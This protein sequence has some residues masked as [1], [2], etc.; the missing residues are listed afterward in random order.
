MIL[1]IITNFNNN[2]NNNN[3][4]NNNNNSKWWNSVEYLLF[5]I[6]C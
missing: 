3:S 6:Y 1:T 4:N 2:D 5:S